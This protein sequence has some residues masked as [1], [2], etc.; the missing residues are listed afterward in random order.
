MKPSKRQIRLIAPDWAKALREHIASQP[1]GYQAKMSRE[2]GCS[3]SMINR[4]K[5]ATVSVSEWTAVLARYTG[6]PIPPLVV[7]EADSEILRLSR[8]LP[9][10]D[11]EMVTTLMRGLAAKA[12]SANDPEN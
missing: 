9:A 11:R 12:R 8:E 3:E 6:L 1:R 2:T 4:I 10:D 5:G 7:D